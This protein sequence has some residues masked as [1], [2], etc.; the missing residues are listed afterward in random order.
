MDFFFCSLLFKLL[1]SQNAVL[2]LWIF[3]IPHPIRIL[4]PLFSALTI[5]SYCF[6]W[7]AILFNYVLL[8]TTCA[9][10]HTSFI[11]LLPSSSWN[12]IFFC[13]SPSWMRSFTPWKKKLPWFEQSSENDCTPKHVTLKKNAR[14][15][16][17]ILLQLF[18]LHYQVFSSLLL[19]FT[20]ALCRCWV[21]ACAFFIW[22][23][24]VFTAN[25]NTYYN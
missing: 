20:L 16:W 11:L 23:Q 2:L 7:Q 10:C 19:L 17:T 21:P 8:R 13:S 25:Q 24:G 22:Q 5:T 1:R 18:F 15:S 6:M 3:H 4:F 12:R 9:N 14:S